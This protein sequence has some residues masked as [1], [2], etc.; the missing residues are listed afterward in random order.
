MT[1]LVERWPNLSSIPHIPLGTFPTATS[2]MPRLSA[3]AGAE[4]WCKRDDLSASLY[5][6]NK[7]RKL[8][9]LLAQA[10]AE[11]AD[12]LVT[13]G[14]AGSH[15]VLAT[16]LYGRAHGFEVHAIVMPQ[17]QSAHVEDN[18]RADLAAGAVLHPIRSYS[19]LPI[20]L[21]GVVAKLRLSG[22]KVFVIGPGGS[23]ASGVLGW[24][25]G[26]LELGRQF[27]SG[28][29]PEPDA[30]VV[31]LGSGGTAA[32]LAVGLA[33]AG[34]M[35]EVV[36]VR[37]TPRQLVPKAMLTALSRGVIQRL[38]EIDDRFPSVGETAANNLTI[39]EGFLGEG[40]GVASGASREAARIALETEGLALDSSYT[41]KA[42]AALLA[43][44]RTTRRGK[45][46]LFVHTLSSAP[47]AP[48]L[49]SAPLLPRNVR[50]ILR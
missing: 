10:R 50:A 3:V 22:R 8:E 49:A 29:V 48:L 4:V 5:G 19:L 25:E 46:L 47:M 42:M 27:D 41:A 15:H 43:Q 35:T 32:G 18:L 45:R 39:E 44:A 1:L 17:E 12:T 21:A 6:G 40:Y 16:A 9:F 14:A 11:G 2:S 34:V 13:T 24:I 7:V 31:A 36:A 26:G 23:D 37:V 30:V 20:A 38:R 28:V 33:A